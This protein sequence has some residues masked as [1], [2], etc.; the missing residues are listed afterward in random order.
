M[1]SPCWESS[2]DACPLSMISVTYSIQNAVSRYAPM[3]RFDTT[4][5][6]LMCNID[7]SH[8]Y[9]EL[10]KIIVSPRSAISPAKQQQGLAHCC[11]CM[12]S[13]RGRRQ[14]RHLQKQCKRLTKAYALHSAACREC[15]SLP[16]FAMSC[17]QLAGKAS[18][19]VWAEAN[20]TARTEYD[21]FY[22]YAFAMPVAHHFTRSV[23]KFVMW[24]QACSK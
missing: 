4:L 2:T 8:T 23:P 18:Y 1:H 16:A 6:T 11:H 13:S 9:L 15:S 21:W 24:S 10:P 7:R 12:S 5:S 17:L 20:A 3:T 22:K 14:A 19:S